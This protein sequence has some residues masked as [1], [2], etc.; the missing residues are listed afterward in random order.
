MAKGKKATIL[1]YDAFTM[2][3]GKGNP[4][5]IVLDGDGYT[6]AEMQ[7]IAARVGYNET[8]FVQQPPEGSS[9]DI[10]FRYFTPG[11]EMDLCGHATVATCTALRERGLVPRTGVLQ[12]DTRAGLLPM[13]LAAD[14]RVTMQQAPARFAPFGGDRAA[15]A[16]LMGL[17]A[18]DLDPELP[19]VYGSTGIWTLLVPIRSLS[20]FGRMKP[21]GAGIPGVLTELPRASLHP[22]CLETADP[23]ARMH[24]RHFSSP[25][26]GTVEDPVTGTASGAMGAYW[27]TYL[28]PTADRVTLTVEQGLEI[29]KDG[30]VEVQAE[31]KQ[32]IIEVAISGTAVY[33]ESFDVEAGE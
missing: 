14:G 3:P 29:G 12:V 26:S 16:E 5:G 8:T 7:Q 23:A 32:D 6:D 30:K 21:R 4:A 20:A 31:R 28:E 18:E 2:E 25:Y 19:I 24:A 33:V 17:T 22:F 1:R 15:L 11:H 13:T 9:G 27:L 10:R